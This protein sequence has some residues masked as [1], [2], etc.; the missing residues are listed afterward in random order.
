MPMLSTADVIPKDGE[1]KT[2]HPNG[3]LWI[4]MRYK[5]GGLILRQ[6]F[7]DDGKLLLDYRYKAGQPYYM[8]TSYGDGTIHMLWT[9]K[10]GV[11]KYYYPDGRLQVLMDKNNKVIASY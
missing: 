7:S 2:Y 11:T 4:K 5:D 10:S 3:K 8:R 6:S 1:V 9:K